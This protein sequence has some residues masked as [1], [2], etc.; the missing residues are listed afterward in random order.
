[1]VTAADFDQIARLRL[2][3][4]QQHDGAG[5]H[6]VVAGMHHDLLASKERHAPGTAP[7]QPTF[8][9]APGESHGRPYRCCSPT[10]SATWAPRRPRGLSVTSVVSS[11]VWCSISALS[12]APSSTE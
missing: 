1:E 8:R 3:L 10:V 5:A 7:G 2:Q 11:A 4:G 12:S 9:F 6:P